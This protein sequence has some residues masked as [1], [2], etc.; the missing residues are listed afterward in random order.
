MEEFIAYPELAD[1]KWGTAS[2][3]YQI[4]GAVGADSRSPSIWDTFAARPGATFRGD[5]GKRACRAYRR[6]DRSLDALSGLGAQVYRFSVSWSRILPSPGAA[7][8]R[9]ALGYYR[10]LVEQL[11]ARGIEPIITLYHWDLPQWLQDRGGWTGAAAVEG[12]AHFSA[13]IAEAL[14][15]AVKRWVTVNEPYC[16]AFH[17]HLSGVHAPGH[18]DE[19]EAL[20]AALMLINGHAASAAEI[21]RVRRDAKVGIV[22]NLSDLEA[23]SD[24]PEDARAARHADLVE[25]RLF[26]DLVLRGRLP[27]D[28]AGYFGDR[29]TFVSDGL[30]ISALRVPLDFIGLNYYEHNVVEAAPDGLDPVLRGARKLPVTGPSSANGVAIYPPGLSRTLLRLAEMEPELPIWVTENGIGL[31][32]YIGPDGDCRDYERVNYLRDHIAALARAR[33]MGARLEGYL[34]WSLMDSFEWASGYQLRYGL[35]YTDYA[36]GE[37]KPKASAAWYAAYIRGQRRL[38]GPRKGSWREKGADH[39]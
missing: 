33:S 6:P 15:D 5:T 24:N 11:L 12:F 27:D 34:H 23:A 39:G 26:L 32:D 36:T 19:G 13:V 10:R 14:G 30:D 20:R 3:A 16:A 8:N 4:E 9:V 28:A 37:L 7:P 17:G 18:R 31:A 35:F 29:L 2:A 1:V 21:R 22:L 25:N 38:S